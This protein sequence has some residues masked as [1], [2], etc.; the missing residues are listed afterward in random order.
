MGRPTIFAEAMTPLQRQQRRRQLLKKNLSR[1]GHQKSPLDYYRDAD[2]KRSQRLRPF[3]E[4]STRFVEPCAGGG[5]LI[6]HLEALGHV[7]TLAIDL[8]PKHPSV[9]KGDALDLTRDQLG[10]AVMFATNL[11]F[12]DWKVFERLLWHLISIAPTWTL[13]PHAYLCNE[14]CGPLLNHA[15]EIVPTARLRL[16]EGTSMNWKRDTTSST[17]DISTHADDPTLRRQGQEHQGIRRR[18]GT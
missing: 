9:S 2:L 5:H 8:D 10:D 6:R 14:Q 15:V 1:S 4:P 7:C 13:Q 17:H 18:N 3:L 12:S 16:F 11:P